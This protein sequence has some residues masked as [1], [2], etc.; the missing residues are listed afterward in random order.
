MISIAQPSI[1]RTEINAVSNVLRSGKL[2]MGKKVEEFEENFANFIG[3]RY[4]IAT[5]NGTTALYLALLALD[6]GPGD[7]VITTPFSFIAS[8][9]AILFT[10]AKPVFVDIDPKTFNLDPKL[11]SSKISQK[12]KAILPVHLYGLPS[13]M[14]EILRVAKKH[15][16]L[17]VEDAC[18][19]HGAA[20]KR[21]K[22]GSFGNLACFS[23]YATKNMTTGE[24]GIITTN[25][26]RL[27]NK[28]KLLRSHGMKKRYYHTSIGYNFRMTDIAATMGIEQ[29]K[30]LDAFNKI[31]RRNA[32]RLSK[33]L[34]STRG[35]VLPES[36]DGYIHAY[37]QYTI[38]IL[39]NFPLSRASLLKKLEKAGIEGLIYYPVSIHQQ[40]A[41]RSL[42]HTETLRVAELAS[43]EVLSLPIHPNVTVKDIDY[44][45]SI[46]TSS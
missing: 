29:L 34:A 22:A 36:P 32:D 13:N 37:H 2:V 24:G 14:P 6:I 44:I 23:F 26:L 35:I 4:S 15:Q 5:S 17:V 10:G 39:K 7:E 11:L 1:S 31:R 46:I 41:Y 27:A 28:I 33:A 19:A 12:T 42:G 9:N 16:L 45:V 21:K 3:T 43:K 25:S 8:A 18:Q 30:K 38:R 20:I 40:K